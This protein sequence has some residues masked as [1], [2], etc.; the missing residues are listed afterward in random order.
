MSDRRMDTI[1][2]SHLVL[3]AADK[4]LETRTATYARELA[5]LTPSSCSRATVNHAVKT[6]LADE[7]LQVVDA[8]VSDRTDGAW[9]SRKWLRI[10]PKGRVYAMAIRNRLKDLVTWAGK[11]QP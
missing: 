8:P 7:C 6:L 5:R 9:M 4:Q 1:S 3:L 11:G 2:V 10:T